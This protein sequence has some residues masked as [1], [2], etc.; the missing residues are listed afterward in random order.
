ML[1]KI[2]LAVAALVV[3]PVVASADELVY[4]AWNAPVFT[5][6]AVMFGTTYGS[7]VAAAS[8]YGAD[9]RLA[10]P[11]AGPWVALGDQPSCDVTARACDRNSTAKLLLIADGILQ[12]AGALAML[13]G[14]LEP[15][16]HVVH[17]RADGPAIRVLPTVVGATAPAPGIGVVG[18]F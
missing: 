9:P 2:L 3:A 13:D 16:A 11:F 15:S 18:R 14:V 7:S 8:S 1:G 17:H 4:D 6:G 5:T 10:I 12:A